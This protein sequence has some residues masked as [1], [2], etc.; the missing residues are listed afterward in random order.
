MKGHGR[1]VLDAFI[2]GDT[3][4]SDIAMRSG[5]DAQ[6]VRQRINDLRK[7]GVVSVSCEI[8]AK[9]RRG[10]TRKFYRLENQK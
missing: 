1:Q 3:C 6:T 8:K 4:V 10:M 7:L 5:I 2:A 9:F